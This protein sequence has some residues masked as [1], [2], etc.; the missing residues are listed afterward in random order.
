VRARVGLALEAASL[1]LS[2]A[3]PATGPKKR[4]ILKRLAALPAKARVF[5]FDETALRLW[6][7]LRAA[8]A[9]VGQQAAVLV[10]GRK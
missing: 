9:R 2:A 1:R 7:P 10:S 6:P 8:W 4:A 3:R 5:L